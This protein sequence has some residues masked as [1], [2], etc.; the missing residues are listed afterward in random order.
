VHP[1]GAD[2]SEVTNTEEL[3]QSRHFGREV[4]TMCRPAE[5]LRA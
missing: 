3:L 1:E 4:I 5:E 2:I